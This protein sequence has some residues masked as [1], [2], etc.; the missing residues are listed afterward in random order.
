MAAYRAKNKAEFLRLSSGFLELILVQDSLL[1]V[2][3]EFRVGDWLE[4]ARR[5]GETDQER[6][7]Y[8]WNARLQ[9]TTWGNRT[10]ADEGGLH[11]YAHKEW[12]GLLKDF[13]YPRWK[14]FFGKL[15]KQLAGQETETID[16]YALEE[17]WTLLQ[18]EY[19]ARPSGDVIATAKWAYE[20]IKTG[21]G[22]D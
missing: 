4:Q 2:R 19:P 18:N 21:S 8:E 22:R 5:C 1:G 20:K 6:R 16:W 7:Q 11:D 14:M 15:E 9:V 3:R 13:Y 10:A 12:A 17:R